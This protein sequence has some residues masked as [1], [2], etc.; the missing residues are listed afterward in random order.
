MS[1]PRTTKQIEN[2]AFEFSRRMEFLEAAWPAKTEYQ[3]DMATGTCW[4]KVTPVGSST[5]LA[6]YG[7]KCWDVLL[8]AAG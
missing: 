7:V 6:A 5:T 4:F 8:P 2:A 1:K 3:V